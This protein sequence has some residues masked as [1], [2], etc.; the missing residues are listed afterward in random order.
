MNDSLTLKEK[1]K[2]LYCK[3]SDSSI[4][5]NT[6]IEKKRNK[7][8]NKKRCVGETYITELFFFFSYVH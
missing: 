5:L 7:Q 1:K 4:Y 2:T 8:T 6:D 3:L